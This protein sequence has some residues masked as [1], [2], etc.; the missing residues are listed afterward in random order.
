MGAFCGA[1][2]IPEHHGKLMEIIE[3]TNPKKKR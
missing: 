3:K 1:Q 2:K